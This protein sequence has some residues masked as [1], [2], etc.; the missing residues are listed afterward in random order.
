MKSNIAHA[1]FGPAN[2]T[3]HNELKIDL[4]RDP[5][6]EQL[7]IKSKSGLKISSVT[8]N[9]LVTIDIY[10]TDIEIS[11]LCMFMSPTGLENLK[12]V[13]IRG[14]LVNFNAEQFDCTVGRFH[15]DI[16]P[17]TVILNIKPYLFI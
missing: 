9:S 12:T 16:E 8:G 5:K 4:S 6:I 11:D 3:G 14:T 15:S 13:R 10:G 1:V 17:A 7:V 2:N